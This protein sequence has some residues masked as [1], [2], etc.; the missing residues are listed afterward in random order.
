MRI[1]LALAVLG[2]MLYLEALR[3]WLRHRAERF[4]I[5]LRDMAWT[6]EALRV[7]TRRFAD[8]LGASQH[9]WG[10]AIDLVLRDEPWHFHV[11]VDPK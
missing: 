9:A 3:G 2:G 6:T 4:R 8:T 11:E 5:A 1:A 7:S 10:N